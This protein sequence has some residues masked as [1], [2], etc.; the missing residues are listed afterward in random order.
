MH[1][2]VPRASAGQLRYARV[3]ALSHPV[4]HRRRAAQAVLAPVKAQDDHARFG[5]AREARGQPRQ[6]QPAQVL[7]AEDSQPRLRSRRG[8]AGGLPRQEGR[9]HRRFADRRAHARPRIRAGHVPEGAGHVPRQP[10]GEGVVP[11]QRGY[12]AAPRLRRVLA[13]GAPGTEGRGAFAAAGRNGGV[14]LGVGTHPYG[15]RAAGAAGAADCECGACDRG[16]ADA[17]HDRVHPDRRLAESRGGR[18]AA[19]TGEGA[20][21]TC[22][23]GRADRPRRRCGW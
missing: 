3:G 23:R 2:A 1:E 11:Y 17:P 12:R 22:E 18:R 6:R 14:A 10:L 19:G 15:R 5:A 16:D 20:H 9:A 13:T 8:G 7:P 21:R 4:R